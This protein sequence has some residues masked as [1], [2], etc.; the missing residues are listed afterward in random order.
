MVACLPRM[1]QKQGRLSQ[2]PLFPLLPCCRVA[3][4]F[5]FPEGGTILRASGIYGNRNVGP[6]T[7]PLGV[8]MQPMEMVSSAFRLSHGVISDPMLVDE[9]VP[10]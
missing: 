1:C 8:L 7:L 10:S 6:V 3:R 2:Y 4:L 5:S 9:R